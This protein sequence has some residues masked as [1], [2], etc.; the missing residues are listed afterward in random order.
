M[1]LAADGT[2]VLQFVDKDGAPT[3][4]ASDTVAVPESEPAPGSESAVG[5]ETQS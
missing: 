5:T 2:P 1:G 3:W 4:S